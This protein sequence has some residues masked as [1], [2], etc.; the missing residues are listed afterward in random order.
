MAA[1][2]SGPSMLGSTSGAAACSSLMH[3]TPAES[4]G[5]TRVPR[6]E[7]EALVQVVGDAV[8]LDE[9]PQELR[10]RLT[11]SAGVEHHR[12]DPLVL[13][14]GGLSDHRQGDRLALGLVPVER[15][16]EGGALEVVLALVP[17]GQAELAQWPRGRLARTR[18]RGGAVPD[19]DRVVAGDAAGGHDED[20]DH[21]ERAPRDHVFVPVA[22]GRRSRSTFPPLRI[23]PMRATGNEPRQ[24][25]RRTHR[26]AGLHE[27]LGPLP[28]QP[29][30][31]D[32]RTFLDRH[33]VGHPG[34]DDGQGAGRQGGQQAVGHGDGPVAGV[35]PTGAER[36]LGI[37]GRGR[38][39]AVHLRGGP[40]G[41][42]GGPGQQPATTDGRHDGVE[43]GPVGQQ[44][45]RRGALPGDDPIVVERVDL[46]RPGV[47]HDPATAALR[48]SSVGS[49][50]MMRAP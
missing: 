50:S 27:E 34:A 36:S 25:G 9:L 12:P 20:E 1:T 17:C 38:L 39:C 10:S 7:V 41:G 18:G 6:H 44:L 33:D 42:E 47:G 31:R 14:G 30:G 24:H 29:H 49:Q 21:G 5:A 40:G 8:G 13:V 4:T 43:R 45:E 3:R 11:G 28:E 15:H 19:A 22:Q 48:L 2:S 46:D 16:V 23:T 35:Q 37:V 32:D 26:R